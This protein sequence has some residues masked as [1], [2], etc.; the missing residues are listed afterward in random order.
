VAWAKYWIEWPTIGVYKIA[1]MMA[2]TSLLGGKPEQLA[3]KFKKK[4]LL[5]W[6]RSLQVRQISI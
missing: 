2:L 3:D 6:L 5:T 1:S 4:F